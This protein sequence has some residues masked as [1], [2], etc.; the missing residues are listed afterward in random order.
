MFPL[1][2]SLVSV[3]QE[4]Q[5]SINLCQVAVICHLPNLGEV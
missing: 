1:Q 2:N 5:L 4:M 3:K